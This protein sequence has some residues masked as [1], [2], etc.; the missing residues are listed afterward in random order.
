VRL[1]VAEEKKARRKGR[2]ENVVFRQGDALALPL[3]DACVD[4][5]TISFGL[6]NMSDRQRALSEMR[7]VLRPGGKV[8][9]LE[10]SQPWRWVRPVY[11]FYLRRILPVIAGVVTGNKG[12]YEYLNESIGKFPARAALEEELRA[13]GFSGVESRGMTCGVVALHEGRKLE[14]RRGVCG[15]PS[16]RVIQTTDTQG[17]A[18]ST[19]G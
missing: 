3:E 1:A 11:F 10:F 16:G 6:R 19:L 9:V 18:D 4:V 8:F 12:A 13:A 17:L 14:S 15:A 2:H 7:R 5:V